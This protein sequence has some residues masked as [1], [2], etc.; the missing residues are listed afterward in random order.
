MKIYCNQSF[1]AVYCNR[2]G[3]KQTA[4]KGD[5]NYEK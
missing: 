2:Y 1:G 3:M 5:D 4:S